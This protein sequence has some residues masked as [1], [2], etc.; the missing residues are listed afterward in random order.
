VILPSD[1]GLSTP[2]VYAEFDRRTAGAAAVAPEIPQEML[3][4]LRVGDL[5]LVAAS[6]SNDLQPAALSMRP[7]LGAL[8]RRGVE[9]TARA[10]L[11]SGSGPTTLYLCEDRDHAMAVSAAFDRPGIVAE[12]P[13]PGARVVQHLAEA[14][15]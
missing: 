12:A 1:G 5:E 7:D 14:G 3:A 6:L 15:G 11:V 13:A 2:S 4:A 8:L 9:A 10:S